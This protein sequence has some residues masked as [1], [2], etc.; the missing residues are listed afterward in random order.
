MD[1][2]TC[3]PGGDKA[4]IIST[5]PGD[6]HSLSVPPCLRQGSSTAEAPPRPPRAPPLPHQRAQHGHPRPSPFL[7]LFAGASGFHWATLANHLDFDIGPHVSHSIAHLAPPFDP[8]PKSNPTL[9]IVSP[10][11]L[12]P[13]PPRLKR[14]IRNSSQD[15]SLLRLLR[16]TFVLQPRPIPLSPSP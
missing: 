9:A 15:L 10:N 12:C 8:V 3:G 13:G 7:L 16:R 6:C 2:I 14:Q 1:I 11:G 5:V 4:L